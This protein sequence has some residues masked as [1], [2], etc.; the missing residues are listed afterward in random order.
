M[1][2]R[3]GFALLRGIRQDVAG[4]IE[5]ANA[6]RP[7]VDVADHTRRARLDRRDPQVRA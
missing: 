1:P 3:L 7:F 2:V 4:R 5:L 6:A